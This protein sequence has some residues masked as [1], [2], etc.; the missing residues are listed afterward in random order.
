MRRRKFIT[1]S[2]A[3]QLRG[4]WRRPL[5]SDS[6]DRFSQQRVTGRSASVVAASARLERGQLREGHNV[7]SPFSGRRADMTNCQY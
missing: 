7:T 5:S 6:G 2:A 3:Q 1:F 4:R